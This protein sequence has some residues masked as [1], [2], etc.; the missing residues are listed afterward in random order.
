LK[1]NVSIKT[2]GPCYCR[3][4]S[5]QQSSYCI[6]T[7]SEYYLKKLWA[8]NET[9]P[10]TPTTTAATNAENIKAMGFSVKYNFF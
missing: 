8:P 6:A 3:S 1:E 4:E 10:T 5:E 9:T 2:G 7:G